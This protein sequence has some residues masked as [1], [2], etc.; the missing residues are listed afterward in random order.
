MVTAREA[1]A[2]EAEV[3]GASARNLF[4]TLST[5]SAVTNDPSA[6]PSYFDMALDLYAYVSEPSG[7]P[8]LPPG[9]LPEVSLADFEHY[10]RGLATSW[11][12]FVAAREARHAQ[13]ARGESADPQ[14]G[15]LERSPS[16]T[17]WL[18]V[19]PCGVAQTGQ[20][21]RLDVNGDSLLQVCL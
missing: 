4:Q 5:V 20:L 12:A 11:P 13:P 18:T 6:S 8:P 19:P 10:L 9:L 1:S 15:A 2:S 3:Q 17:L 21:A 16:T 7:V 14:R